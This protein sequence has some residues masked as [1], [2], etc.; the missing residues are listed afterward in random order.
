MMQLG[1]GPHF[2]QRKEQ[3]ERQ[4]DDPALPRRA[5]YYNQSMRQRLCGEQRDTSCV[6]PRFRDDNQTYSLHS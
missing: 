4:T 2:H 3:S 5:P 1:R 6:F